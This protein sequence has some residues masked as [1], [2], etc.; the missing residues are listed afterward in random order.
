MRF[1]FGVDF[2]GPVGE[3]RRAGAAGLVDVLRHTVAGD[4]HHAQPLQNL[5]GFYTK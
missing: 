5:G 2:D 4:V 1:L 3:F